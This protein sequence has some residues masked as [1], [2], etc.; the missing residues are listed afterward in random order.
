MDYRLTSNQRVVKIA[1]S[2]LTRIQMYQPGSGHHLA[3]LGNGMSKSFR[4]GLRLVVFAGRCLGIGRHPSHG[5]L[6]RGRCSVL[7]SGRLG[8]RRTR[9]ARHQNDR[10][11]RRTSGLVSNVL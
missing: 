11:N 5:R 10:L 2:T 9:H 1:R 4:P 8:R 6:G 7:P 3:D